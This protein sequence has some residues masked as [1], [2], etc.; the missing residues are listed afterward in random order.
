[1]AAG[2]HTMK[3]NLPA[4]IDGIKKLRDGSDTLQNGM[5]QF[6]ENGIQKLSQLVTVDTEGF[7]E[8]L[9]AIASIGKE[10]HSVYTGLSD[11]AEGELRFIYR[12]AA[13]G[14]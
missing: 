2:A 6:N 11:E 12:T 14:E 9:K 1:L 10:Y 13:I 4:L 3:D 7:A 8:R 5:E